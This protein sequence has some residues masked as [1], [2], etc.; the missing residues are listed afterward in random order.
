ME[1]KKVMNVRADQL[2]DAILDSISYEAKISKKKIVKGF[3]YTKEM[4]TKMSAKGNILVTIEDLEENR[5]YAARFSS[6]QG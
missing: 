6:A 5:I 4:K 1:F 2:Y 3:S